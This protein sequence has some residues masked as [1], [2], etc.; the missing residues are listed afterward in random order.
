[1]VGLSLCIY[2]GS[3][4]SMSHPKQK[5]YARRWYLRHKKEQNE[6]CKQWYLEHKNEQRE[7]KRLYWENNKARLNL[8]KKSYFHVNKH[9][10]YLYWIEYRKNPINR[11]KYQARDKVMRAVKN[12]KLLKTPC[13]C[14]EIKVEGHHKDYNKPLE[15]IWLCRKH[16]IEADRKL[17]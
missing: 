16:H 8:Q 15:V 6:R 2:Y 14:G 13:F 5:I 9:K 12:G 3:I 7:H 17:K 1:M 10:R 11:V 4:A